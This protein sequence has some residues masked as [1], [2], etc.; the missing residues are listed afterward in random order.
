MAQTHFLCLAYPCNVDG[1]VDPV[2]FVRLMLQQQNPTLKDAVCRSLGVAE[3]ID[4]ADLLEQA[5][6]QRRNWHQTVTQDSTDMASDLRFA[7]TFTDHQLI[8]HPN[9]QLISELRNN[10][11]NTLRS[12]LL[13]YRQDFHQGIRIL[14]LIGH[15]I[16]N[17]GAAILQQNPANDDTSRSE[18]WPWPFNNCSNR[19]GINKPP[20]QVT[21]EARQG[22][23]VVFSSGLLTPEWVINI[24]QDAELQQQ[25]QID[26]TIVIVVD[27]CYSGTWVGR[28]R[29]VLNQNPLK[30]TRILLQTSCGSDEEAYGQSFTPRF[31]NLNLGTNFE[32]DQAA[33]TQTPQFFDSHNPDNPAAP[34]QDIPI[35]TTGRTFKFIKNTQIGQRGGNALSRNHTFSMFIPYN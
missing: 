11:I 25:N 18:V 12:F 7:L 29:T 33:P 22:D 23:L 31:V 35:G 19:E 13:C 8:R 15:A 21:G 17:S 9:S 14:Y 5:V 32:V 28:M 34:P 4:D 1:G 3:D 27:A 20:S 24:L 26:N 6:G 16:S 30:H 10:H 2:A